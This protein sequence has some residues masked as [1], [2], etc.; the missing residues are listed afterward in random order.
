[1]SRNLMVDGYSALLLLLAVSFRLLWKLATLVLPLHLLSATDSNKTPA[2]GN[3]K[4][5]VTYLMHFGLVFVSGTAPNLLLCLLSELYKILCNYNA[6]VCGFLW[7]I[8]FMSLITSGVPQGSV[9]GQFLLFLYKILGHNQNEGNLHCYA[10][11]YTVVLFSQVAQLFNLCCLVL[12][13]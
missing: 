11:Y 13:L 12:M 10:R 4:I 2:T 9:L 7:T 8:L 5:I 3:A 1:M 6:D